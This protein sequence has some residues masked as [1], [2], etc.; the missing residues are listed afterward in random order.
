MGRGKRVGR[1]VMPQSPPTM[2]Y[3]KWGMC[4]E[5]TE[6]GEIERELVNLWHAGRRDAPYIPSTSDISGLSRRLRALV[7]VGALSASVLRQALSA[8]IAVGRGG[9]AV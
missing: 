1:V 9:V 3:A 4:G 5:K 8:I 7:H 6:K 2:L